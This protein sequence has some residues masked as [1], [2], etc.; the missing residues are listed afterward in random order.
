MLKKDCYKTFYLI[1]VMICSPKL[2]YSS[3]LNKN[4][5][6]IIDNMD[7]E[8]NGFFQN[9]S[10]FRYSLWNIRHH[11]QVYSAPQLKSPG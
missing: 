5:H 4:D 10:E 7:K 2:K 9:H 6:D 3:V 8:L 1:H 11:T